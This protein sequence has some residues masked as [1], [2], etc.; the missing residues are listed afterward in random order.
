MYDTIINEPSNDWDIFNWQI[1]EYAT[2]AASLSKSSATYGVLQCVIVYYMYMQPSC[3]CS[4]MNVNTS[5]G[6]RSIITAYAM[7][8]WYNENH[9]ARISK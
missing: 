8:K 9:N 5:I 2:V 3:R 7:R 1:G 6:L 4:F